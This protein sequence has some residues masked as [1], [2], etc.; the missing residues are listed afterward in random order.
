MKNIKENWKNYALALLALIA[1]I[2]FLMWWFRPT[3]ESTKISESIINMAQDSIA[4]NNKR[5]MRLGEELSVL[6]SNVTVLEKEVVYATQKSKTYK[7]KY[8]GL[9]SDYVAQVGEIPT[10]VDSLVLASYDYC[11]S[12]IQ[13]KD[14]EIAL[15]DS[16]NQNLTQQVAKVEEKNANHELNAVMY[17]RISI[18]KDNIIRGQ[19]KQI[20]K[21]KTKN[22]I[23]GAGI[24]LTTVGLILAAVLPSVLN[25]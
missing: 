7:R 24:G 1:V 17:G 19:K 20:L 14:Y 16:V 10:S 18:E 13:S 11:D 15:K 3:G 8:E 6:K 5:N 9:K 21:L 23:M 2:F 22:I 12:T 4:R 25:K